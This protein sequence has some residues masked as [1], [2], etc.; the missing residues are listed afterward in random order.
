MR[1]F[2]DDGLLDIETIKRMPTWRNKRTREGKII[3]GL[4]DLFYKRHY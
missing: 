1:K 2:V 4:I 3:K